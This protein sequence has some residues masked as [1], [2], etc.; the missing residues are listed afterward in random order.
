[1]QHADGASEGIAPKTPL[2]WFVAPAVLAI[3]LVAIEATTDVDREITRYFLDPQT[4]AFP[5]RHT[6]LLEVAMHQW[7]KYVVIAIG[8]L[9]AVGLVLTYILPPWRAWRRLL[10]F[11][12]LAMSLG[13]LSVTAGKAL[14][15]RHCPWDIDEFGGFAPYTHLLQ[16]LPEGVEPGRCFPAGHSSTGFAL[17]AFYFAGYAVGWRRTAQ[18]ALTIALIA[19]GVLGFGRIVQGAHFMTHVPWAGIYCWTVMAL[20]YRLVLAKRRLGVLEGT[21]ERVGLQESRVR[22]VTASALPDR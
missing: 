14:S 22:R 18:A 17:L 20:L 21:R 13:P 9:I 8:A 19:G 2:W 4:R 11:L 3:V 15:S 7:A 1:M 5:L 10:V 6:F 12:V 16:P